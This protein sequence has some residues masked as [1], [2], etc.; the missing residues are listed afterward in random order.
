M[1]IMAPAIAVLVALLLAAAPATAL[2]TDVPSKKT[3]GDTRRNPLRVEFAAGETTTV[4]KGDVQGDGSTYY[5]LH[6]NQGRQ[7]SLALSADDPSLVLDVYDDASLEMPKGAQQPRDVRQWSGT[8]D[9]PAEYLIQVHLRGERAGRRASYS[10]RISLT[11]RDDHAK[12]AG[13]ART[14]AYSCVKGKE[15]SVQFVPGA[16]PMANVA[17]EGKTFALPL[18]PGASGTQYAKDTTIFWAKDDEATF[19]SA[20][21]NGTCLVKVAAGHADLATSD[22]D[23]DGL[24]H[25]RKTLPVPHNA[26]VNASFRDG[27]LSGTG[28]CNRYSASYTTTGGAI[29]IGPVRATRM[30]CND[31]DFETAFF[32]AL[33]KVDKFSVGKSGLLLSGPDTTLRFVAN[34]RAQKK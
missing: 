5:A 30:L 29:E 12:L 26:K 27:T 17:F 9:K 4:V 14:V 24:S 21:W 11:G 25:Q 16:A 7:L 22:W 13:E 18:V 33:G 23:L 10:L 8:L 31:I 20:D 6:A 19:E 2:A 32:A 15:L 1:P 3:R 34:A 28:G